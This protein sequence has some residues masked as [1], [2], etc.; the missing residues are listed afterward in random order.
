MEID[1]QGRINLSLIAALAQ[2][3]AKNA[4]KSAE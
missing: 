2:L 1:S 4:A 3:E